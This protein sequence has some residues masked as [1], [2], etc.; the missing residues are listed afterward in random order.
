MNKVQERLLEECMENE[1]KLNDWERGFIDNLSSYDDDR[2]LTTDQ[3]KT[4]NKLNKKVNF[5]GW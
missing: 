5:E 4:L 1:S 3:N 2:A